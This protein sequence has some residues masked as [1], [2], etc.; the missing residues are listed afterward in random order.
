MTRGKR[1]GVS[2]VSGCVYAY[3][4]PSDSKFGGNAVCTLKGGLCH[5]E[6]IAARRGCDLQGWATDYIARQGAFSADP[7][8]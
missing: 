6:E 4:T 2:T 5:I 3:D 1:V 7:R 8:D